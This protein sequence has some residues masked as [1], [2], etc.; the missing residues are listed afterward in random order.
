V[1][2]IEIP[3]TPL[4]DRQIERVIDQ[5]IY[6]SGL[7]VTMRASLRSYPGS[8]HWHVKRGSE[9][10]TLEITFWPLEHRAW[11]RVQD[12]RKA[13]W[14]EEGLETLIAALRERMGGA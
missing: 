12:G 2:E 5:A 4:S 9:S 6:D 10:G 7:S 11:F 13:E 14:I 1:R 3:L 8:V